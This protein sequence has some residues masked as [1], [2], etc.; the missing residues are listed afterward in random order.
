MRGKPFKKGE[1]KG[2][3]KGALNK[4]TVQMRTVKETVLEVFNIIQDNP[5]V[6]LE[7][8]AIDN[9]KEF[10]AIA[11]KLIPTEVKGE[12]GVTILNMPSWIES[13]ES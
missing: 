6:K 9:P 7:Q 5:K 13:N 2:R 1:A 4:L 8:F 12:V 10:Y 3:P 11:A